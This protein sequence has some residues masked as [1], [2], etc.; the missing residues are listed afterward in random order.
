GPVRL[1]FRV[2]LE[3]HKSGHSFDDQVVSGQVRAAA[4]AKSGDGRVDHRRVCRPDALVVEA[5]LAKAAGLEVLHQDVGPSGQLS[6]CRTVAVVPEIELDGAL[7]AVDGQ[8][9]GRDAGPDWRHPLARVVAAGT[10]DL[11]DVSAEVAENH[12]AVRPGEH[13]REVGD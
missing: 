6:G 1:A 4:S 7:V 3:T 9:V 8:V 10:L 2:A 11:Y 5:E 12:G 13:A